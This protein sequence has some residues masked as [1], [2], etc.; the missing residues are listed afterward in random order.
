MTPITPR[1]EAFFCFC[2][3]IVYS[4]SC[5]LKPNEIQ[6]ILCALLSGKKGSF[7]MAQP[8]PSRMSLEQVLKLVSELS[9][10]EQEQLRIKLATKAW[11]TQWRQL[12]S[13]VEE[14]NRG[15]SALSEEEITAE[16]KAIKEEIRRENAED[17]S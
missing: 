6:W 3:A 14:D 8:D 12:V 1:F 9:E 10:D 4:T 13:K 11:G 17:C 7:N 2:S 15:L 5:L 16:M